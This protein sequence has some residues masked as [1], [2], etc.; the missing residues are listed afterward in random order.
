MDTTDDLARTLGLTVGTDPFVVCWRDL[1]APSTREELERLTEWV[2]WATHRYNLDHKV[3]PPCWSEHGAL[4][5][6]LS[7]LRTFWEACYQEDAA[8]SDPLAF[9]RDLTLA[10]RR[11]RDWSS[12][13]GCTRTTHRPER[14]D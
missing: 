11:L 10:L 1:D 5:E 2:N 9:H 4:T 3:V 12:L 13:L 7:A 14:S 6:E 8:P